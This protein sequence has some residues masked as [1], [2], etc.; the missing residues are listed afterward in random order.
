MSH[1]TIRRIATVAEAAEHYGVCTKTIRRYITDGRIPSH[2]L[3]PR[4]IR[5]DLDELD[6]VLMPRPTA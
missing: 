2:R 1:N 4:L 5:V 6:A 3:G